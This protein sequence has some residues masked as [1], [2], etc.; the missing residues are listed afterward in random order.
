MSTAVHMEPKRRGI[1]LPEA[2]PMSGVFR[3]SAKIRRRSFEI[4]SLNR[5]LN[6][7]ISKAERNELSGRR[8][9]LWPQDWRGV[10]G[11]GRLDRIFRKGQNN[12][13]NQDSG[14]S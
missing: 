8:Q 2:N 1:I 6:S 13:D 10:Y 3:N 4:C 5:K 11:G 12:D 9:R 7:W 14:I